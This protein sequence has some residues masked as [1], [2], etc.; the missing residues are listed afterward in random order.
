MPRL[1]HALEKVHQSFS[2]SLKTYDDNAFV[3]L[4]IAQTL[5]K[6]LLDE[7]AKGDQVRQFESVFEIGCGTGFLTK[8]L[9]DNCDVKQL[10]LNDLVGDCELVIENMISDLQI[11]NV[12]WGFL[13][14]D[15]NTIPLPDKYDLVCSS[16]TLQWVNDMPALLNKLDQCLL[17]DGWLML[18]SFGTQHFHQLREIALEMGN[19]N[20]DLS[21]F[22]QDDWG[23]LLGERFI[24]KNM[25][26]HTVTLMFDSV[27]E[28]LKHL[29]S[30]GVNGN[31]RRQW[32]LSRMKKFVQLYS[33]MFAQNG[34][35]P[36]SY[37]PVY[38]LAKKKVM[39][40]QS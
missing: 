14:G 26:S 29:R 38:I 21:Y 24:L 8:A 9:L 18:S 40:I 15:V 19:N 30:T 31:A 33:S 28:V 3:Q 12:S 6:I 36:L 39:N 23:S 1:K 17:P 20:N 32:S 5:V 11:N 25:Q 2:R 35:Y 10:L 7:L 34:Q 37:E 27:E 13:A 16:S 22:D 4:E